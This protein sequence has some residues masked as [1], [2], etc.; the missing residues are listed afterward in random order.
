MA[1]ETVTRN[2]LKAILDAVLPPTASEYRKLLW[3][4]SG[5]T[6][7]TGTILSNGELDGFDEVEI[8]AAGFQS[9]NYVYSRCPIGNDGLIQCFTTSSAN[10]TNAST[11]MN[12]AT[13]NYSVS[14]S[15][16]TF[17]NGQMTYSGGVYQNW[18][19]RAVPLRVYGIKYQRVNP[20]QAEIA[21]VIVEQN[22]SGNWRYRIWS[23]GICE[24]WYCGSGITYSGT[25]TG[26]PL[27]TT[28]SG[29]VY[30]VQA[31]GILNGSPFSPV[32]N[33]WVTSA[34]QVA[35][36]FNATGSTMDLLSIYVVYEP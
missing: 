31:S 17:G 32:V 23:S 13:R 21:D 10:T 8:L 16:I 19:S 6:F 7:G 33:V 4:N 3:T 29:T 1:S 12:T 28:Y 36:S 5:N 9:S 24:A 15:G 11:F 22:T 30:C 18:D 34:G 2:D 35:V 25:N 20:P 26:I 14:S 27:P